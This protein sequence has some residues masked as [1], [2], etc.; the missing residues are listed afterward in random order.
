MAFVSVLLWILLSLLWTC[1]PTGVDP[2]LQIDNRIQASSQAVLPG[3][4]H[5]KSRAANTR[6]ERF[7][8]G[9]HVSILPESFKCLLLFLCCSLTVLMCSLRFAHRSRPSSFGKVQGKEDANALQETI[10]VSSIFCWG[11]HPA[12]WDLCSCKPT[13]RQGQGLSCAHTA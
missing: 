5:N 8:S 7:R 6:D 11:M 9:N 4:K 3:S 10:C 2:S 1:F 13:V 12:R